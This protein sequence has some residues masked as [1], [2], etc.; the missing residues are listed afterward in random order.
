[1]IPRS[2]H[3]AP[4]ES[5]DAHDFAK[6]LTRGFGDYGHTLRY[7]EAFAPL[8]P[9]LAHEEDPTINLRVADQLLSG[10]AKEQLRLGLAEAIADLPPSFSALALMRNLLHLVGRLKAT[11]AMSPILSQIAT[12]FFG[13]RAIPE[14][15]DLF[16]FALEI[17]AGMAPGTDVAEGLRHLVGC[18]PFESGYAPMVFIGLCRAEPT[19]FPEHM[20]Y[21][22]THFQ[23]F[24]VSSGASGAHLTARRFSHYVPLDTIAEHIYRL[25]YSLRQ[26]D[27]AWALDNWLVNALF[28]GDRAPLRLMSSA[29]GAGFGA[30]VFDDFW[31]A[32]SDQDPPHGMQINLPHDKPYRTKTVACRTFLQRLVAP[33]R[34]GKENQAQA[35]AWFAAAATRSQIIFISESIQ[36]N[37]GLLHTPRHSSL[38]YYEV[39]DS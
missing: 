9:F 2:E 34:S 25:Q 8:T 26:E 3:V 31:I 12:G 5:Y 17:V 6:W 35:S 37:M 10:T 13:R 32:R 19:L 1:M 36:G 27:R 16:A 28:L 33:S 38:A 23:A 20:E 22:R 4:L 14:T 18:P 21:L 30:G 15:H 7:R 11:E 39:R 29:D 24:H